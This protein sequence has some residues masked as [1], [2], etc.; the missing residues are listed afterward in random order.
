MRR[1][2]RRH[3]WGVQQLGDRTTLG[4]HFTVALQNINKL[5][6]RVVAVTAPLAQSAA[7]L[8]PC[9]FNAETLDI[10]RKAFPLSVTTSRTGQYPLADN[11]AC[12]VNIDFDRTN[13]AIA[14]VPPRANVLHID[15]VQ[16]KPLLDTV[17]KICKI[18]EKFAVVSHVLSWLDANATPG[19]MRYYWPTMLALAPECPALNVQAPARFIEPVGVAPLLPLIREAASTVAS[20]LLLPA[21]VTFGGRG[22]TLYF[23]EQEFTHSSVEIKASQQAYNL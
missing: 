18:R 23:P 15:P 8:L 13:P 20:A 9:M 3:I 1:R 16:G 2:S 5:N 11:M 22:M 12:Y 7:E 17:E 19:A 14:I 21:D 6:E 10:L 4:G